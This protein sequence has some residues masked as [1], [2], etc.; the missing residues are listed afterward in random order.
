MIRSR[1]HKNRRNFG[2][3]RPDRQGAGRSGRSTSQR[4]G[5]RN[6][7]TVKLDKPIVLIGLMGVGKTTIGR[8]L[9]RSIGVGFVDSDHEIEKAAQMSVAEIFDSY[10]EDEFR[11]VERRVI[12]RLMQGKPK[13]IATGGGAFMNEE[14]RALIKKEATTIWLNADIDVLVERTSRRDTRPLLKKGNPEDI[15]RNLAAERNPIYAESTLQVRS[16]D[17]PH[18]IVVANMVK[19]LRAYYKKIRKSHPPEGEKKAK[20][21]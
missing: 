18:E 1:R 16:S 2:S 14:T 3:R 21:S 4:Q 17:G 11:A 10:G 8:R 6:Q 9:S 5:S 19:I 7:S 20:E 15:L 13:V 12:N